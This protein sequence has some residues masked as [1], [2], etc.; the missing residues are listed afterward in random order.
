MEDPTPPDDPLGPPHERPRSPR[1][2]LAVLGV[3][4]V[5]LGTLIRAFGCF[6]ATDSSCGDEAMARALLPLLAGAILIVVAIAGGIP[7]RR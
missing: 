6:M 7:R 4:L 5:A 2:R 3:V 1:W